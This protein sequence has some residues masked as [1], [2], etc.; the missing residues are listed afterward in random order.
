MTTAIQ[1]FSLGELSSSS[2]F[3]KAEKAA[4][5][6]PAVPERRM[7]KAR[8]PLPNGWST[9]QEDKE[10]ANSSKSSL[11]GGLDVSVGTRRMTA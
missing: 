8:S 3:A 1:P 10:N 5:P 11:F 6:P 9:S 4:M 2:S 7:L